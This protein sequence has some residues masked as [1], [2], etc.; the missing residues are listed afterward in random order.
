M[1]LIARNDWGL[2]HAGWYLK[3]P[4][5][6]FAN[7]TVYSMLSSW[8]FVHNKVI[9]YYSGGGCD[10]HIMAA[11]LDFVKVRGGRDCVVY[12]PLSVY[13]IKLSFH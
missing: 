8:Y 13:D 3:D 10:F 9:S 7:N 2:R 1:Q 11:V 12:F 4:Y 6:C 5:R